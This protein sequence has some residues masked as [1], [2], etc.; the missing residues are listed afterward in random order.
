MPYRA[1]MWMLVTVGIAL[2][3]VGMWVRAIQ[4][5]LA[6]HQTQE[7]TVL[8]WGTLLLAFVLINML[9]IVGMLGAYREWMRHRER[10]SKQT[11]YVDAWKIAGERLKMDDSDEE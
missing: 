5:M 7:M 11:K 8:V 4:P 1:L 3:V 9:L 2:L 6:E 10:R